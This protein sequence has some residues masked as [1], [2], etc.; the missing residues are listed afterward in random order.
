MRRLVLV[1]LAVLIA[2][3]AVSCSL[4]DPYLE[5]LNLTDKE[6]VGERVAD[7]A[8]GIA[9]TKE[10]SMNPLTTKNKINLELYSLVFEGLFELDEKFEPVNVLCSD[11]QV[12]G[13][14]YTF[15]LKQGVT[16]SDGSALTA[17]DVVASLQLAKQASSY[18]AP[19]LT[20]IT[21]IRAQSSDSV[22]ITVGRYTG[23]LPRLLD[24]P[25]IKASSAQKE[26]AVGTGGY[27]LAKDEHGEY[28]LTARQGWHMGKNRPYSNIELV[29]ISGI[30]EL[31]FG[32]ESRDID[33][34]T[35]DSTSTDAIQV[36]GE[37]E[38]RDYPTTIFQYIGFNGSDS[39]L[40][41]ALIRR[42]VACSVDRE[43]A[44]S[45]EYAS[46]AQ[47]ALLTVHPDSPAY[48]GEIGKTL[49]YSLENA[50]SLLNSAGYTDTDGDGKLENAQGEELSFKLM[51]NSE[52]KGRVAT[53]GRIS[54]DMA[55]IGVT[56]TVE[57]K[58]WADYIA[59]LQSGKFD[60]YIAEINLGADF[61]VASLIRT[62]GALNYGRYSSVDTDGLLDAFNAATL[63]AGD[64]A[65]RFYNNFVLQT[66]IAPILF[67]KH[68]HITHKG[69][70]SNIYFTQRNV[71]YKFY[72]WKP[73]LK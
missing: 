5:E 45:Q 28:K 29:K 23:N 48:N 35:V 57:Q 50:V 68:T 41:N 44:A 15:N 42:A 37:Y 51:V 40:S 36:R 39:A 17:K 65:S 55:K 62:E 47:P 56:V 66:P 9:Y 27:V 61:D 12:S 16:F 24:V 4:E 46:L 7:T 2:F 20:N 69:A 72:D 34:V 26:I 54:A 38:T 43:S 73:I 14:T 22:V 19:R 6:P 59:A 60:A 1:I 70:F 64:T 67:R 8:F 32:F 13:N 58:T 21:N 30:D 3:S 25:I 71:F 49:E 31:V 11:Y 33:V 53:A 63:R 10:P 18:Y 52:N